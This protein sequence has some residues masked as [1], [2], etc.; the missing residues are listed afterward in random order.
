MARLPD[1]NRRSIGLHLVDVLPLNPYLLYLRLN[2]YWLL[3]HDRLGDYRRL[4]HHNRLLHHDW[5]GNHRRLLNNYRFGARRN[6]RTGDRTANHAADKAWPEVAPATPPPTTMAMVV[7]R[8]MM[9]ARTTM[10][11]CERSH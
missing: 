8:R 6:H 4:L 9:P 5:R 2:G 3:H 7:M 11:P 1:S 10:R